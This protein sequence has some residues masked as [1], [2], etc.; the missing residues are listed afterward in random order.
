MAGPFCERNHARACL[1]VQYV[2][3]QPLLSRVI[4][5]L[6]QFGPSVEVVCHREASH[7]ETPTCRAFH[8]LRLLVALSC[9]APICS[10]SPALHHLLCISFALI[11]L[12]FLTFRSRASRRVSL[13]LCEH[14]QNL[15]SSSHA[16]HAAAFPMWGRAFGVWRLHLVLHTATTSKCAAKQPKQGQQPCNCR[17]TMPTLC[18]GRSRWPMHPV[19]PAVRSGCTRPSR[20]ACICHGCHSTQISSPHVMHP[21]ESFGAMHEYTHKEQCMSTQ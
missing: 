8:M 13:S 10:A 5:G 4:F 9:I 2:L 7:A 15:H 1:T 21:W 12:W 20:S 18:T 16:C 17:T 6:V 11:A 19:R 14:I 3:L